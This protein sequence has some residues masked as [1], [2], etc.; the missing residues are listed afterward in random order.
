MSSFHVMVESDGKIYKLID[1]REVTVCNKICSS[2]LLRGGTVTHFIL[3][4][5][6]DTENIVSYEK[7]PYDPLEVVPSIQI[8]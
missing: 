2:V 5:M 1:D 4:V 8:S 6:T 3:P 7:V